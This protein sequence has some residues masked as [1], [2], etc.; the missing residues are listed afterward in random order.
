MALLEKVVRESLTG[1]VKVLGARRRMQP[2]EEPSNMV[3]SKCKGLEVG[4]SL[5]SEDVK[6]G[7]CIWAE[8]GRGS[9]MGRGE[10]SEAVIHVQLHR[11]FAQR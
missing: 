10:R 1:E 9:G 2:P 7:P 5:V 11:P 6:E 8:Q 4:E 3:N